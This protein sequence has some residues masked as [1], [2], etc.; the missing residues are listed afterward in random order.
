MTLANEV[1]ATLREI[2]ESAVSLS[3]LGI[4]VFDPCA[5]FAFCV[6]GVLAIVHVLQWMASARLRSSL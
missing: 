2:R 6:F 3:A 5:V 4:D 1:F